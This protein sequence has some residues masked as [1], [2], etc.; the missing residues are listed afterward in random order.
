MS[1]FIPFFKEEELIGQDL[2]G[3]ASLEMKFQD[4]HLVRCLTFAKRRLRGAINICQ[5]D[6]AAGIFC[7]LTESDTHFAIW[8]EQP[9]ESQKGW[10]EATPKL[11]P[12]L[13]K[14]H[15]SRPKENGLSSPVEE[16]E[17]VYAASPSVTDVNHL[18]AASQTLKPTVEGI[19]TSSRLGALQH[20]LAISASTKKTS[21]SKTETTNIYSTPRSAFLAHF[22]QELAQH[23]GPVADYLINKLLAERP[24]IQPQQMTEAIVAEIPDSEE[25]QNIQKSL[26]RLTHKFID[27][28]VNGQLFWPQ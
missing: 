11:Q 9:S 6:I 7:V 4:K 13:N 3:Q 23:M 27:N 19:D 28:D 15:L 2:F 10:V 5:K 1:C 14:T 17:L 26:D 25:S 20:K 22:N 12:R 24:N 18:A 8:R 16:L 21:K